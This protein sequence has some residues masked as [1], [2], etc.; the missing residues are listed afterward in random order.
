MCGM[1]GV[2]SFDQTP[3]RELLLDMMRRLVHRGPDGCGYFQDDF[4]ALG[5]TRLA[6]VDTAGGAQPMSNADGSRWVSF[7]GEIF[8]YVELAEELRGLGHRF[9][10]SSDTE[11]IVHA[12]EEWG[13][14]CFRRFNGQWAVAL[15]DRRARRLVLS[16]DR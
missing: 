13:E 2:A 10:T 8:N 4:V 9:R 6:I 12:W 7:N 14:D 3:D 16:R 15:W 5:H 11:V 1:C